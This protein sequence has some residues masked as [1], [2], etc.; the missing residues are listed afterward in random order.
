MIRYSPK[1]LLTLVFALLQC[2]APL[3]HAHVDGKHSGILPPF[4]SAQSLSEHESIN[5]ASS[6]ET[7]E[8]PAITIAHEFQRNNQF[9]LAQ[10]VQANIFNIPCLSDVKHQALAAPFIFVLSPYSKSLP[11]APPALS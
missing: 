2:V 8:S 6:V 9:T 11:Q 7:H 1:L 5:S 3:V 10:P 4:L